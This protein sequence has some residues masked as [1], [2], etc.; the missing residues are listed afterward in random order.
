M[1]DDTPKILGAW[2][3]VMRLVPDK[4]CGKILKNFWEV[5]RVVD[6]KPPIKGVKAFIKGQGGAYSHGSLLR[7]PW[8]ACNSSLGVAGH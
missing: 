5:G 1:G 2:A 3:V 4:V 8:L 6:R 7:V